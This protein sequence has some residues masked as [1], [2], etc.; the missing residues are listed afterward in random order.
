MSSSADFPRGRFRTTNLSNTAQSVAAGPILVRGF[1]LVGGA[2]AEIVI[3]RAPDDSPVYCQIPVAIGAYVESDV[4]F[5]AEEGLEVIT[6]SAA[7][8]VEVVVHYVGF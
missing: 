5:Y 1:R 7:G 2:A 6:A 4:P 3:F 8:D